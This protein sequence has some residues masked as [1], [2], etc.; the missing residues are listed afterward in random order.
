M[1]VQSEN[2]AVHMT[3][4]ASDSKSAA[5][6]GMHQLAINKYSRFLHFNPE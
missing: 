6:S 2:A 4:D 5:V 1:S 3:N